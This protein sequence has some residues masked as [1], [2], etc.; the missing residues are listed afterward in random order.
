MRKL[1]FAYVANTVV[2]FFIVISSDE[3]YTSGGLA[4][5]AVLL[6]AGNAF[7]PTVVQI[8]LEYRFIERK[9]YGS[10]AITQAALDAAYEPPD[11]DLSEAYASTFKTIALGFLFGTLSPIVYP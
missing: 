4:E 7:V 2:L 5:L 9:Y 10:K 1:C 3:W 8:L 11:F 6:A